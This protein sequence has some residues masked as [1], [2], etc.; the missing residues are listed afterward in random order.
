MNTGATSIPILLY[1]V[2]SKPHSQDRVY[3]IPN[4]DKAAQQVPNHCPAAL[5]FE[6]LSPPKNNPVPNRL[7]TAPTECHP[8]NGLPPI[9]LADNK[10]R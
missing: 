10:K 7:R 9:G 4:F 8:H 1:G 3:K 5:K 2:S 6:P